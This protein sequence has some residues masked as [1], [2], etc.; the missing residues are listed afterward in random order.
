MASVYFAIYFKFIQC[1][2]N[3]NS[4]DSFKRLI[5][6]HKSTDLLSRLPVLSCKTVFEIRPLDWTTLKNVK[7]LLSFPE[8]NLEFSQL[9]FV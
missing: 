1:F 4:E 2:A 8:L 3:L 6:S 9:E 7:Q 5:H